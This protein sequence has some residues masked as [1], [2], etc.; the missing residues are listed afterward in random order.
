MF[1]IT[2]ADL[3]GGAYVQYIYMISMQYIYIYGTSI[4]QRVLFEPQGMVYG[5]PLSSIQHALED[6]GIYIPTFVR[7]TVC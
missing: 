3:G 7:A 4:F 2:K 6:P 1:D 5:H